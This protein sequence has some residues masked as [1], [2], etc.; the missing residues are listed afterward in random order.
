MVDSL[1]VSNCTCNSS[2]VTLVSQ[3]GVKAKFDHFWCFSNR[4]N[5]GT[6]LKTTV[7]DL[8]VRNSQFIDNV[9]T[10]NGGALYISSQGNVTI[11]NN[12]FI[13]N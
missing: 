3:H 6:C 12:K 1:A 2:C 8:E 5:S 4:A 11:V 10:E 7:W 13:N 9:A